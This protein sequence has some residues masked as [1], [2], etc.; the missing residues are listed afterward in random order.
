MNGLMFHFAALK[1]I[2]IGAIVIGASPYTAHAEF[3][4][5]LNVVTPPGT[6]SGV[7][8]LSSEE[9]EGPSRAYYP[10][11]GYLP[12]G[13]WVL[14]EGDKATPVKIRHRT[15]GGKR[16]YLRFTSA[17]G[18]SGH[19][20]ANAITPVKD[21]FELNEITF[22]C[23][24]VFALIVPVNA[25]KELRVYRPWSPGQAVS[26]FKVSRTH[27]IPIAVTW[28]D[29]I[30][31]HDYG[32]AG[33]PAWKVQFLEIE[34]EGK[35]KIKAGFVLQLDED[36]PGA[37]GTFRISFMPRSRGQVVAISL[38]KAGC[39]S[40]LTNCFQ[41]YFGRW[42]SDSEGLKQTI[43]S[44]A[45]KTCDVALEATLEA[46]VGAE[47]KLDKLPLSIGAAVGVA[48]AYK[49]EL[50]KG[51]DYSVTGLNDI[52]PGKK[53]R[54]FKTLECQNGK[55]AGSKSVGIAIDGSPEW[56]A[57][58]DQA[59]LLQRTKGQFFK[60]EQRTY[61]PNDSVFVVPFAPDA[62]R[63]YFL[64]FRRLELY[65]A[66]QIF[67]NQRVKEYNRDRVLAFLIEHFADWYGP[68]DAAP[69]GWSPAPGS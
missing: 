3:C 31:E 33:L 4:D 59:S 34:A 9:R 35:T 56:H 57:V 12:V 19:I 2:A 18:V 5:S 39:L 55:P 69:A 49:F 11:K 7:I 23:N 1:V 29:A 40:N 62:S 14:P 47:L 38:D 53:A 63:S 6:D 45:G 52:I 37:S 36:K 66:S 22:S 17:T 21:F 24:S 50:P 32:P 44:I 27:Y 68:G 25:T 13:T 15:D 41:R 60:P 16:S 30:L 65:L 54:F 28:K 43:A 42:F 58:I 8:Y 61:R 46:K 20:P 67:G 48:G 10:R 64:A 26:S 51:E